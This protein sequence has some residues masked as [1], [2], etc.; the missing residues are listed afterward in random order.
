MPA[1]LPDPNQQQPPMQQA[2]QPATLPSFS[3]TGNPILD[4][5]HTAHASL[6]PHAQQA[7]AMSLPATALPATPQPG[8]QPQP[9][10][11]QPRQAPL[12]TGPQPRMLP[13]TQLQQQG[14]GIS[15]IHNPFAR[16]ALEVADAVGGA[17]F[18]RIAAALP[19][20]EL[21]HEQLV[22]Q[23]RGNEAHEQTAQLEQAKLGEE[24][25]QTANLQAQPELHQA[26]AQLAQE[27]QHSTEQH[28]AAQLAETT[29]HHQQQTDSQLR[30]HGY[31]M[32]ET[33]QIEPLTY[34]E[35]SPDQ[36]AVHDL[37][38]SQQEL[39]DANASLS[40]AKKDGIPA[41]MQ[42]AQ[43]RIAVARQ[44][45]AT[46]AGR[47]GLSRAQYDAEYLGTDEG[48]KAL[49]GATMDQTGK[50]MG[51]KM[52]TQDKITT[53]TRGKSEQAG[54]IL[55][56]GEDLKQQIDL[57]KDKLGNISS[58]WDAAKNGTPLADPVVSSLMAQMKSYAA[59][60]AAAHGYKGSQVMSEFEK[61]IGGIPKNP[62]AIKAAIDGIGRTMTTISA[63]GHPHGGSQGGAPQGGGNSDLINVQIPGQPPGQIHAS[64]KDA[65]LKKYPNAKV[66]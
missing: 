25:A 22:N 57:H 58:Y 63:A 10:Q 33:G 27:K 54:I 2:Q 4:E 12:A 8:A 3:G 21:H 7:L 60:Q 40:K 64:Q 24:A 9:A 30:Q 62:E 36:Q 50:P 42:M 37:K 59:L 48:G 16:H 15:Q 34:G 18:P 5:L 61:E 20:T 28:Q 46:A 43:Q 14:S 19:G 6:S 55:K 13:S 39:T 11:Q 31:K 29:N 65:F 38:A 49:P 41:T 47:L 17:F 56:A 44:N 53:T 66:Q 35:M 52:G 32:G 23:Q 45:A 26:Q 1:I 51:T